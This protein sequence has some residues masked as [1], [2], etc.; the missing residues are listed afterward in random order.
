MG[1]EDWTYQEVL[2]F[3]LYT[4]KKGGEW[5]PWN[6]PLSIQDIRE[7]LWVRGVDNAMIDE[8]KG[9]YCPAFDLLPMFHSIL[10]CN[11]TRW[12][13]VNMGWSSYQD[14]TFFQEWWHKYIT[15]YKP[16]ETQS[17]YWWL[18][19]GPGWSLHGTNEALLG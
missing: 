7:N 2:M 11:A 1:V 9:L 13:A 14:G 18:D 4:D 16:G 19:Q 3:I 6:T 17:L 12:D 15:H 5:I 8:E 10:L